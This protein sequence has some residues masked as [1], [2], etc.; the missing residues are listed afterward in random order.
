M[1]AWRDI[2]VLSRNSLVRL[3]LR[4]RGDEQLKG[5]EGPLE[6]WRDS[7]VLS[8]LVM[9]IA[10]GLGRVPLWPQSRRTTKWGSRCGF[11]DAREGERIRSNL[12]S[13]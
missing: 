13:A 10:G 2:N 8:S 9:F 7:D 3:A 1:R 12:C 11:V 4:R 5:S 6:A